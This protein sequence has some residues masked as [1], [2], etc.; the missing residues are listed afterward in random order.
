[1]I[2]A[3]VRL[4]SVAFKYPNVPTFA[5]S[6]DVFTVFASKFSILAFAAFRFVVVVS[7][8]DATSDLRFSNSPV[9]NFKTSP[10]RFLIVAFVAV[11]LSTMSFFTKANSYSTRSAISVI[12][13][14][15]SESSSSA[16]FP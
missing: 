13:P 4:A 8:K 1:M 7:L 14:F 12:G 2:V 15:V 10:D 3:Y 9:L 5:S 6:S 11:R 16:V